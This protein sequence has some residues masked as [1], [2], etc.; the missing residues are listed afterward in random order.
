MYY[1]LLNFQVLIIVAALVSTVFL[2][3][4][5][6]SIENKY[7]FLCSI[8][9]DVYAIG[10]F[11]EMIAT[12]VEAIRVSIAFEYCGLAFA[13]LAYLLFAIEY[14]HTKRMPKWAIDVLLIFCLFVFSLVSLGDK[15]DWYYKDFT[16]D[17]TGIFPHCKKTNT[18]IFY[19]FAI[20]EGVVL[21][22]SSVIIRA[23]S[24]KMTRNSDKKRYQ[25]LFFESILPIAGM[26]GTLFMDLGGWDPSPFLLTVL[27]SA[28]THT[29]K[30]G[31]FF[32]VIKEAKDNL[33]KNVGSGVIIADG[34]M[35]YLECNEMAEEIY[36]E[37]Q[38]LETG[39]PMDN[40]RRDVFSGEEESYFVKNDKFYKA[41]VTNLY[42]HKRVIGY[43]ITISDITQMRR[44]L[45]DIKDLKDKADAA[46]EA[47][48]MFLANMSHEIRT[49]LNAIIG[50]AELSE[51][52]YTES[53]LREYIHQIKSSGKILL[54]IVN[55]ILDFSKAESGRLE[56]VEVRFSSE[57]F[58]NSLINVTN[59]RIGDKPVDF[60]VDIDPSIPSML[61]GDD[62]HIR[63]IFMNLL[64]N[65]DKFTYSGEIKLSVDGEFIGDKYKLRGRIS[66]TGIGIKEEDRDKL[67]TAF[68][69][70]DTKKNRHIQGSGLGLSIFSLL[71]KQMG[72]TYSLES[73]YGKGSTFSFDIMIEAEPGQPFAHAKRECVKVPHNS[74]FYL[75]KSVIEEQ[76]EAKTESKLP[77]Y[78]SK[79]VL[80]V[81]D[82]NVNVKVLQAFLRQFN[83]NADTAFSGAEAIEK[84]KNNEY[85]LVFMDH[86]MPEMDGVEAAKI[87]RELDLPYAATMPVVACTANVVKGVEEMFKE[88][89]MNGFVPKPIQMEVLLRTLKTFFS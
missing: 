67:F 58:F 17:Y 69:Q 45:D 10:Y 40:V 85:N 64:S 31:H 29:L 65:A 75:Y 62:V 44:Q 43:V 49:P 3:R 68:Q 35:G 51:K 86:M 1:F 7:L 28:V 42:E 19:I 11:Q 81:D 24:K 82:N 9:V 25:V 8:C 48:S 84:V 80:V 53:V 27:V 66:D 78:S 46:N 16:I 39:F 30:K 52:E 59:M 63:Q 72:G 47:K 26:I 79:R 89:G 87:I 71:V 61:V 41:I 70:V 57:E 50:M 36:P 83:I 13:A 12:T 18:V 21:I 4:L 37:L 38:N 60:L 34:G 54:G 6:G 88:A 5:N 2:L 77:D 23:T 74:T 22:I 56:L 73:E 32:D 33:L 20:Y 55:D 15:T 76:R 14:C